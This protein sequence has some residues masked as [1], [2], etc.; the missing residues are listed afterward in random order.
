MNTNVFITKILSFL[1]HHTNNQKI[2][3]SSESHPECQF[4]VDSGKSEANEK[5]FWYECIKLWEICENTTSSYCIPNKNERRANSVPADL[6]VMSMDSQRHTAQFHKVCIV[7]NTFIITLRHYLP[8]SPWQKF[9]E[10]CDKHGIY[11]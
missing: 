11:A 5:I 6:K 4:A 2:V 10:I 7:K 1:Y 3:H 8:M 9:Y